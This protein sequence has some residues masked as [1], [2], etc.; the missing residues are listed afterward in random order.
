MSET[1]PS[2]L[3]TNEE[4]K[5]PSARRSKHSL[6]FLD[7]TI[8]NL[9]DFVSKGYSQYESASTSGMMQ[10][11]DSRTKLLFLLSNI[12]LASCLQH[13]VVLAFLL[14][15]VL[16]LFPISNLDLLRPFKI[17]FW[18]VFF[19]GIILIAPASLNVISGGEIKWMIANFQ[20]EHN[21]WIYHIPDKIGISMEGLQV[22]TRLFLR[23]S[24][25][26]ILTLLIIYSTSFAEIIK[27]LRMFRIPAI[28]LLSITLS[29]KFIFILSKTTSETY[30]AMRTHWMKRE[31]NDESSK[32]IA[33]RIA[34]VFRKSWL[35][36]EEVYMAMQARGFSGKLQ[37][38]YPSELHKSDY[39]FSALI[40]SLAGGCILMEYFLGDY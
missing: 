4:H 39:L 31:K 3:M 35:K 26:I 18:P 40:I 21:F 12:I 28:F 11:L 16:I 13:I 8:K 32:I 6:S 38:S 36:Y 29:Y 19:F 2:F 22:V 34:F 30:F 15:F 9:S 1:L 14:T 7:N 10:Q 17:A 27:A 23:I 37:L 5:H 20:D 25:S 33:G 24:L